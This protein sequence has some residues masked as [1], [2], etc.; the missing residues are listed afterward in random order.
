MEKKQ[1]MIEKALDLVVGFIIDYTGNTVFELWT[2][3]RK[4]K[5]ILKQDKKNIEKFFKVKEYSDLYN[6]IEQ[7]IMFEAFKEPEF[8][9]PFR[10]IS[11]QEDELWH[12]FE[13]F[14]Y[15]ELGKE[16][17]AD[18]YKT[19]LI[20]CINN[21]NEAISKVMIDSGSVFQMKV[22]EKRYNSI[23]NLLNQIVDT[24][25][26]DT[27]LQ[28]G[29]D[30]LSFLVE[31][32]ESIMKSYRMDINWFR[33]MQIINVLFTMTTL[34]LMVISVPVSLEYIGNRNA[35][36]LMFI[37]LIVILLIF[38]VIGIYLSK[39]LD[40]LEKTMEDVRQNLL[41]LHMDSY[42]K[43]MKQEKIG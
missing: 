27:R 16:V 14:I 30:E 33:R 25:D 10:L 36:P 24:L 34:F 12:R 31:Q 6:L 20:R 2:E 4:I 3:K 23:H 19:N 8:Y 29:N 28:E 9:S 40:K 26:V 22:N 13:M 7:F 18:N 11:K 37:Y 5:K 38:L 41:K 17:T 43:Q 15:N 39:R 35:F 42:T 32:I 21:H 1:Q